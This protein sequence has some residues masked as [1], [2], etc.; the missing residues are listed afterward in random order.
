MISDFMNV[1]RR[2]VMYFTLQEHEK[3]EYERYEINRQ[4]LESLTD[5]NLHRKYI[6]LKRKYEYKKRF[7]IVFVITLFA[8]ITSMYKSFYQF[9]SKILILI[10]N[11]ENLME[12]TKVILVTCMFILLILIIVIFVC[13][14]LYLKNIYRI[15]EQIL[16]IEEIRNKNINKR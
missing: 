10:F 6:S 4:A 11:Q 1:F 3:R 7:F 8:I 13:I 5:R 12:V 16:L 2:M 9:F 15:Y 14:I